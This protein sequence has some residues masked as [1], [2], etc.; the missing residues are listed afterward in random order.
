MSC[1]SSTCFTVQPNEGDPSPYQ[2]N[3]DNKNNRWWD[4]SLSVIC[5]AVDWVTSMSR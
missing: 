2:G 3:E 1:L 4:V 5:T